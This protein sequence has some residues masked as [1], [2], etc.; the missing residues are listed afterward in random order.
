M[1]TRSLCIL[2]TY[3]QQI[4][5]Q[6]DSSH[7]PR[8]HLKSDGELSLD[9]LIFN[10]QISKTHVLLSCWDSSQMLST[11]L[12]SILFCLFRILTPTWK[13]LIIETQYWRRNSGSKQ[14]VYIIQMA[15]G[16][17]TCTRQI[18]QGLQKK[19]LKFRL[20]N[21]KNCTYQKFSMERKAQASKVFSLW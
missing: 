19:A 16:I 18:T 14:T 9:P 12:T 17:A 1:M 20:Q 7:H 11:I 10:S 5:T 21:I 8:S 15:I 13:E 2:K 3:S 4:G 6:W